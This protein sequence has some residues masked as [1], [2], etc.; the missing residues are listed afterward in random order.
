MGIGFSFGVGPLRVYV[1]LT[2]GRRRV[3]VFTHAG[4]T[5]RHQTQDTANRCKIGRAQTVEK[6]VVLP[7]PVLISRGAASPT[8]DQACADCGHTLESSLSG[9]QSRLWC[10]TCMVMVMVTRAPSS[11]S[12][13]T[14]S[15]LSLDGRTCADCGSILESP[16]SVGQGMLWC[17]R[18]MVMVKQG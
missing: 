3:K 18:C 16:L 17:P 4:C 13:L 12:R 2:S 7:A 11:S 10:P 9:G 1:P 5:I 8:G 6:S 15:R 14:S